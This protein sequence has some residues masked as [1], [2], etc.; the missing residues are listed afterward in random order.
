MEN[1]KGS[2]S[3]VDLDRKVTTRF[4]LD[5]DEVTE[6]VWSAEGRRLA[7][8]STRKGTFNLYTKPADG[9]GR[10]DL[11]ISSESEK[12]PTS[13]S[14][15]A[16]YLLFDVFTASSSKSDVWVVPLGRDRKAFPFLHTE[17]NES[18]GQFSPDGK[19]VLYTSDESGRD[20]VY[21]ASFPD[22]G[23]RMRI[24]KDGGTYPRWRR[25]GKEIFYL[26][27]DNKLTA[28]EIRLGAKVTL[29]EPQ[30]KE[31]CL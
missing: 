27:P 4:T 23:A 1:S 24:S 26:T 29:A 13:W 11:L 31:F 7:F 12:Y 25:D 20:E 17:F 22:S 2:T 9:S 19:W 10:E 5:E 3:S 28:V 16:D 14:P 30:A 6:A 8:N 15:R 21:I 18:R